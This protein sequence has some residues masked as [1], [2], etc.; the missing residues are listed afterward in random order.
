M[1]HPPEALVVGIIREFGGVG[2]RKAVGV[3]ADSPVPCG[4]RAAASLRRICCPLCAALSSL[5]VLAVVAWTTAPAV[6]FGRDP[7]ELA[8]AAVTLGVAHAPGYPLWCLIGHLAIRALPIAEPAAALAMMCAFLLGLAGL[9]A[10]MAFRELAGADVPALVGALALCLTPAAWDQAT[11]AEVYTLDLCLLLGGL[12]LVLATHRR[13]AAGG[14]LSATR[15]FLMGL[16]LASGTAH[17]GTH[18][19]FQIGYLVLFL[20][21]PRAHWLGRRQIAA[22]LCGAAAGASVLLYLPLR[23]GA[24]PWLPWGLGTRA[25]YIW[26]DTATVGQVANALL[27]RHFKHAMWGGGVRVWDTVVVMDLRTIARELTLPVWVLAC[28]GG[29]VTL[30]RTCPRIWPLAWLALADVVLFWNYTVA[31][32]DVFFLPLYVGVCGLAAAGLAET[33]RRLRTRSSGRWSVA[34]C[35]LTAIALGWTAWAVPGTFRTLDRSSDATALAYVAALRTSLEAPRADAV[36]GWRGMELMDRYHPLVYHYMAYGGPERLRL[37]YNLESDELWGQF[38][39]ALGATPEE[40]SAWERL[41]KRDRP[42]AIAT[43]ARRQPQPVY[44][45]GSNWVP[46]AGA[47]PTALGWLTRIKLPE[48]RDPG[49]PSVVAPLLA[50]ARLCLSARPA[51]VRQRTIAFAPASDLCDELELSGRLQDADDL[52]RRCRALDPGNPVLAVRYSALLL[53]LD[54]H[55]D[56]LAAALEARGNARDIEGWAYATRAVGTALWRMGRY[57]QAARELEDALA[58]RAYSTEFDTRMM[59]VT[60]YRELGRED[61][62]VRAAEPIRDEI[63]AYRDSALR[64]REGT[65]PSPTE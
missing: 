14:Q 62:M 10:F 7:A 36:F 59:L 43:L 8:T 16:V 31:D 37:W 26:E 45:A 55:D 2:K 33:C 39:Q 11:T 30:R 47:Q 32:L 48:D 38:L 24:W 41:P 61:D 54:R 58:F 51:D 50:W 28:A 18:A 21:L 56:A 65:E 20:Q 49:D 15:A 5:G 60:C 57:E 23:C 29:A 40:R 12:W 52:M 6:T 4:A 34:P 46:L 63:Y 25:S 13:T 64:A 3:S 1:G 17:R 44:G 9:F 35:A 27:A 53:S 42:H 19:L 22:F